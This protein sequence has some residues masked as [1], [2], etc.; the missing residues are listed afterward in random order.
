VLESFHF[1]WSDRISAFFELLSQSS[2]PKPLRKLLLLGENWE[3]TSRLIVEIFKFSL[4]KRLSVQLNLDKKGHIII[5]LCLLTLP[6]LYL[7]MQGHSWSSLGYSSGSVSYSKPGESLNSTVNLIADALCA[8]QQATAKVVFSA[9]GLNIF[10]IDSET[11]VLLVDGKDYAKWDLPAGFTWSVGSEHSFEWVAHVP[12]FDSDWRFAWNSTCGLSTQRVGTIV[13]P[14][15]GGSVSAHYTGQYLWVFSAQGLG[16]DAVGEVVYVDSG[17]YYASDLPISFWWDEGSLH[18]YAYQHVK[19]TM[20]GKRYGYASYEPQNETVQVSSSKTLD[21]IYEVEYRLTIS[22]TPTDGGLISPQL[23]EVWSS[24]GHFISVS[25]KPNSGY[26]L[27]HWLLDGTTI[28]S[29]LEIDVCMDAPHALTAIF[30]KAANVTFTASGLDSSDVF[31]A[32]LK[33]DGSLYYCEEL[34]LTLSWP[35]GST[36]SFEWMTPIESFYIRYVL[37]SV[38]GLET[39]SNG[40]I[41]VPPQGGFISAAYKKQYEWEFWLFSPSGGLGRDATGA[42]AIIDGKEYM[43]EDFSPLTFWW[44]EGSTH[45]YAFKEFVNSTSYGKRYAC[46]NPPSNTTTVYDSGVISV[47]Y[48]I[49]YQIIIQL[50]PNNAGS[51]T[52]APGTYWYDDGTVLL[53]TATPNA[54]YLFDGWVGSG[55]GSYSG[56]SNPALINMTGS[57]V[58]TAN[59]VTATQPSTGRPPAYSELLPIGIAIICIAVAVILVAKLRRR[60]SKQKP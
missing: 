34:P 49:E 41:I 2:T 5:T 57:I 19:C 8:Q 25:A 28:G 39:S 58:Q 40:T 3:Y 33:V 45:I 32:V 47:E 13:V 46:H 43:P 15:E 55:S 29:D 42:V 44:D 9:D 48:H 18:S 52:P 23:G 20:D 54:G 27:D 26:V 36:H 22:A 11:T 1:C 6:L 7:A 37:T 56:A 21:P 53:I 51:T 24:A 14:P 10:A 35:I 31:K 16:D 50:N 12:T 4:S 38:S 59:F 17:R 30:S 60:S